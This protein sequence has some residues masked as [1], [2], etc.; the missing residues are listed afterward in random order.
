[1][2]SARV[3]ESNHKLFTLH[4]D[5]VLTKLVEEEEF[6]IAHNEEYELSMHEMTQNAGL[7]D[8]DDGKDKATTSEKGKISFENVDGRT[9]LQ[10]LNDNIVVRLAYLENVPLKKTEGA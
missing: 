5:F 2:L 6:W 8:K 10:I 7:K 1:V 4:S 9:C 3:L